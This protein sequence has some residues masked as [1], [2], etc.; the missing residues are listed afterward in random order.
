MCRGTSP[1]VRPVTVRTLALALVCSLLA[2]GC[3]GP[4]PE[5]S[6]QPHN[7]VQATVDVELFFP[8]ESRGDHCG[9]VFPLIRTNDRDDPAQGALEAL[10][11]GPTAAEHAEGYDS[12]FT[13]AGVLLDLE[14]VDGTAH[15]TFADLRRA[16]PN[17]ATPCG[18]AGLLAQLDQT[19]LALDGITATRYALADQTAFYEWLQ[20]ADPDAPAP[21]P[22]TEPD[23]DEPTEREPPESAAPATASDAPPSVE[24]LVTLRG[25]GLGLVDFGTPADEALELLTAVIGTAPRAPGETSAWVE[26]TGWAELGLYVGTSTDQWSEYDGVSRFIGWS[27]YDRTGSHLT[28]M[29]PAG[30]T[31]GTTVTQLHA[32]FGDRLVVESWDERVP[33]PHLSWFFWVGP[34]GQLTEP[35]GELDGDPTDGTARVSAL[36]AGVGVGW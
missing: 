16:I 17:A 7:V 28:L 4:A 23:E 20:L 32:L 19:L 31:I 22:P 11:A 14:V 25:D 24:E 8:N 18:A 35:S 29:S 6:A 5:P 15:V 2:S 30:M 10:L 21:V 26:Y 1:A 3:A 12:W 27:L 9:E 36:R 13:A 33:G 34:S